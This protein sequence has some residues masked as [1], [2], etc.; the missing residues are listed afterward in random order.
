MIRR[1]TASS[2]RCNIYPELTEKNDSGRRN[3]EMFSNVDLSL[4]VVMGLETMGMAR[5][6]SNK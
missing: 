6:D 3:F 2:K 5:V 4:E 1:R